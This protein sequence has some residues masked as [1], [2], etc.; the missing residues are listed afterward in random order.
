MDLRE[1]GWGDADSSGVGRGPV[2]GSYERDN[3]LSGSTKFGK[4]KVCLFIV[5]LTFEISASSKFTSCLPYK[6]CI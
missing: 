3:E 2:D 5:V 6:F 4:Y 1:T